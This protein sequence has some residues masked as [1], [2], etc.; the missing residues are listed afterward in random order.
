MVIVGPTIT[1]AFDSFW[2]VAKNPKPGAGGQEV[3]AETWQCVEGSPSWV[4]FKV[5][6]LYSEKIPVAANQ[7]YLSP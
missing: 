7:S 6:E 5:A 3:P 4:S 1:T 2:G